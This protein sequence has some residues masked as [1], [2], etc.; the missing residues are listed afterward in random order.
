MLTLF[1][2]AEAESRSGICRAD[3]HMYVI[4]Y[5]D[6]AFHSRG[7]RCA[8]LPYLKVPYLTVSAS[9]LKRVLTPIPYTLPYHA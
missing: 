8:C 3:K 5:A 2:T 7:G 6:P 1:S 4:M 9:V